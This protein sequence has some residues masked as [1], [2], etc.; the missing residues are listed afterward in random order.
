MGDQAEAG[1]MLKQMAAM[2]AKADRCDWAEA[3]LD[4][5]RFAW[6]T[7]VADRDRQIAELSARVAELEGKI[8]ALG[9][10]E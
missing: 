9:G 2:R 1:R 6:G 10:G 4:E 3:A 8:Q 5:V 7:E